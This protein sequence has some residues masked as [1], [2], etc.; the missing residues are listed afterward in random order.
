MRYVG[1]PRWS[2]MVWYTACGIENYSRYGNFKNPG[3][4]S[5]QPD[6]KFSKTWGNVM[7]IRIGTKPRKFSPTG[8]STNGAFSYWQNTN[9]IACGSLSLHLIMFTN[10]N[11]LFKEKIRSLEN[12]AFWIAETGRLFYLKLN[13]YKRLTYIEH[14]CYTHKTHG[15][16]SLESI[17]A[18]FGYWPSQGHRM[19]IILSND[20]ALKI[21]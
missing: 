17:T 15:R 1:F 16:I 20:Y 10:L 11:R 5:R 21:D 18:A 19:D 7:C 6:R 12:A 8:Y 3:S 4:D 14:G 13:K 9:S 2:T